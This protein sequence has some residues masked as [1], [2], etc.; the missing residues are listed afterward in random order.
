MVD[1]FHRW[2]IREN[3]AKEGSKPLTLQVGSI[4]EPGIVQV[5]TPCSH[6]P[7]G[8]HLYLIDRG[9]FGENI[10]AALH[11][12]DPLED[13]YNMRAPIYI[14]DDD[15]DSEVPNVKFTRRTVLDI[16]QR[17]QRR[18]IRMHAARMKLTPYQRGIWDIIAIEGE[19]TW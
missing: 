18:G 16:M 17:M 13:H 11:F 14:S 7:V 2:A 1:E 15:G 10:K 4:H 5:R 12:V 8:E 19:Y 3:G 6:E 9:E